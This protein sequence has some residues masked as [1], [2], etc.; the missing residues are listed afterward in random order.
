MKHGVR[1]D[2]V[3]EGASQRLEATPS[4]GK[5]GAGF[6]PST[7]TSRLRS[8]LPLW[9][10]VKQKLCIRAKPWT[11]QRHTLQP[12]DFSEDPRWSFD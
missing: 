7:T 3:K 4:L 11:L 2:G 1:V 10:F 9:Q 5:V 6:Y 12:K 8:K